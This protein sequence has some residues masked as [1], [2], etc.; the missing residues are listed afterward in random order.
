MGGWCEVLPYVTASLN[1]TVNSAT[2]FSAYR[3]V[4]GKNATTPLDRLICVPKKCSARKHELQQNPDDQL[5]VHASHRQDIID[6]LEDK[7]RL[8]E[9]L[10]IL[11]ITSETKFTSLHTFENPD[12]KFDIVK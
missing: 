9:D 6:R 10:E 3:L 11:V 1:T 12:K 2:G 8:H 7:E 5:L 4:F